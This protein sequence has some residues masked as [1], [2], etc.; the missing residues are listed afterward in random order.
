MGL[1]YRSTVYA[2]SLITFSGAASA[3]LLERKYE[4]EVYAFYDDEADL[5]WLADANYALTSGYVNNSE[6]GGVDSDTGQMEWQAAKDWAASLTIGGKSDWRLPT[7]TQPDSGCSLEDSNGQDSG[8]GCTGS[9]MGN[10]FYNVLGGEADTSITTTH[11]A[12]FDLFSN[13]QSSL[14]W[15]ATVYA[16]LTNRA[17]GINMGVGR[18]GYY[19]K[20]GSYY[21]WAVR[22][23]DVSA[24]SAVPEPTA[25][26]LIGI[27][28][29]GLFAA[30]SRRAR[31][32]HRTYG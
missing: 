17:W 18:Q 10:L 12:N 7:T 14:Y 24:S 3:A 30:R 6:L 21:A 19:R 16:P 15:S 25:L 31:A 22:S 2:L 13:V 8:Y 5:T 20:T 29:V 4:G 9:E 1:P 27:G 32:T 28:A 11:N 23:G 26:S